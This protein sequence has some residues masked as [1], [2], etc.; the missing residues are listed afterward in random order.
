MPSGVDVGT[1]APARQ[2]GG[3]ALRYALLNESPTENLLRLVTK[4]RQCETVCD[5]WCVLSDYLTNGQTTESERILTERRWE[6]QRQLQQALTQLPSRQ[7]EAVL[8]ECYEGLS[9]EA[10]ADYPSIGTRMRLN[11]LVRAKQS[12][13]SWN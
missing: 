5:E 2:R 1:L 7:R 11:V 8:L 13:R 10:I 12:T 4:E 6:H 9:N 3:N